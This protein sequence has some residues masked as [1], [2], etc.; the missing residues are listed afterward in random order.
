MILLFLHNSAILFLHYFYQLFHKFEYMKW[1]NYVKLLHQFR[2]GDS[3]ELQVYLLLT[4]N[5]FNN[6]FLSGGFYEKISSRIVAFILAF[7]FS[8]QVLPVGAYALSND[9][10]NEAA[11]FIK[12]KGFLESHI[13]SY[14]KVEHG[15]KFT[16]NYLPYGN[17][18]YVTY[19]KESDGVKLII[20]E[21][22]K[23]NE[24]IYKNNGYV[25]LDGERNILLENTRTTTSIMPLATSITTHYATLEEIPG[26]NYWS[27][28]EFS[29]T[30][31]LSPFTI[32]ISG[33]MTVWIAAQMVASGYGLGVNYTGFFTKFCDALLQAAVGYGISE[34][35][36]QINND[37]KY[38]YNA[39]TLQY[40]YKIDSNAVL[41]S[42]TV[43]NGGTFY[44]L[45]TYN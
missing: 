26:Y 21:G 15:I 31:S 18:S 3:N 9:E 23:Q 1:Y 24:L 20:C 4:F 29:N 34:A 45:V 17:I 28:H 25:Y 22:I 38:I 7:V 39:Q 16:V 11:E 27:T 36:A 30:V 13:L 19:I 41:L 40:L 8:L 33:S 5:F 43:A 35:I 10:Y 32:S 14:E 6:Y 12:S 37:R 2:T 42:N 44:R